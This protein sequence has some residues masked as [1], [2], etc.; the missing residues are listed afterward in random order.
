MDGDNTAS[1]SNID[2]EAK[3]NASPGMQDDMTITSASIP[4]N[5]VLYATTIL[6]EP[7]SKA[8]SRKI[9]LFG[10]RPAVIKSDKARAY[11]SVFRE[12]A[13]RLEALLT[14]DLSIRLLIV[15]K[16]RRPDLD[17]SL[18]LDL[19]QGVA[20]ENDRQIKAKT[21]IWGLDPDCPRCEIE[22]RALSQ[23]HPHGDARP[24]SRYE[25]AATRRS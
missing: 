3:A 1:K 8:N 21:V 6:G 4:K 19:L 7:A 5:H 10:K 13:P 12:Q 20:Y 17:E 18:I 25:K 15:Y 24:R 11:C 14:G 2:G 9:V 23:N 16:S 22:I